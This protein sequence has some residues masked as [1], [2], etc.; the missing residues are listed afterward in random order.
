VNDRREPRSFSTARNP[1]RAYLPKLADPPATILDHLDSRFPLV[2]REEWE[3]RMMAGM[4]RFADDTPVSIATPYLHGV[5]IT[6]YRSVVDEP[7]VPFEE[8]IIYRDEHILVADKPHFLP[9]VPTGPY[10][11]ECLLSRVQR[12][13]GEHGLSPIHRLDLETAGLVLFSVRRETRHLYHRLFAEE[14]VEKEYLAV[15][16]LHREIDG[17]EWSVRNRLVAG[18]PWFRMRI[19]EGEVNAVTH[20]TLVDRREGRGL[21]RLRPTTGKKH[22]LRIHLAW[23]GFPILNDH[24]YPDVGPTPSWDYSRPLQLLARRLAFRDPLTGE[25]RVFESERRL[26]CW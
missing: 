24:F 5:T 15:G 2:G 8:G 25:D 3:R 12:R 14:A 11:N 4:V 22:Q 10:V 18:E 19:V 17:R 9:V 13:T 1:S 21:F 6:Y 26:E 23:L 7:E 16:A 20:V